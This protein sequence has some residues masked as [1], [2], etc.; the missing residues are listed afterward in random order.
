MDGAYASE[1]DIYVKHG[2]ILSIYEVSTLK[3]YSQDLKKTNKAMVVG[4]YIFRIP[5]LTLF[6]A[7]QQV[8]ERSLNED[9]EISQS[10]HVRS[11]K[12]LKDSAFLT[13]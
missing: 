4:C 2:H 10:Q 6:M 11:A 7:H 13:C 8:V 12:L 9:S 1:A 5:L 3:K